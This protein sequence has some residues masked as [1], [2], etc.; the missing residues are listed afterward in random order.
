MN[1]I[2]FFLVLTNLLVGLVISRNFFAEKFEKFKPIAEFMDN[3]FF[4]LILGIIGAATGVIALFF[5]HDGMIFIVDIL[6]STAVLFSSFILISLFIKD[7]KN[8]ENSLVDFFIS[9]DEKAGTFIGMATMVIGI[10][11]FFVPNAYVL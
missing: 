3:S 4:R 2:Y 8:E 6:P 10:I 1:Q 5:P 11:H 9:I 7:K